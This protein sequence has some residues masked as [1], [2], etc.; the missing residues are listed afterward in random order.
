MTEQPAIILL[1]KSALKIAERLQQALPHAELHGHARRLAKDDVAVLFDDLEPHLQAL[2]RANRPILA[3]TSAAIPIRLLAPILA[4][5]T[6]EPPVLAIA[7]DGSAVVPLLGGHRGAND[8]SRQ[9][10][11][12]LG[13]KPAITTAGDLRLGLALDQPPPGWTIVTP[14]AIKP[15]TAAL[16]A[17]D[18]VSLVG[19]IS[20]IGSADWLNQSEVVFTEG[21]TSRIV[22]TDQTATTQ[23]NKLVYHPTTLALGVGCERGM[24]PTE[25]IDLVEMTLVKHGLAKTSIAAVVSIEL[26]AAEPAI[27]ALANHLGVPARFFSAETLNT[28]KERLANPSEIVFKETG[29]HGVAEGAALKSAGAGGALVV[30]KTKS[31]RATCAIARAVDVVDPMT[32]GRPQG[33]L[34]IIGI[35]PGMASWRTP[36]ADHLLQ[37]ADDW[38]GYHGYLDILD[39]QGLA[40]AAKARHGFALGEEETRARIAL[41][42]A[43]NG[44]RVALISSGDAGIYA[45]ASLAFELM[46]R[47][48]NPAWQRI[49]VIVSPGISALQAAASRAGAPLGH[50]FCAISLSDLLTPWHVIEQRL[51]AAADGDFIVALYNPASGRRR[52]GLARALAILGKARP[53]TTPVIIG[54]NLGREGENMLV[55]TLQDVDQ[56]SIDMLSLIIIGSSQTKAADRLH[57]RPFVYTPRGYLDDDKALS[58]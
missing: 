31:A 15:V 34:A 9:V 44:R 17:G 11:K 49:E 5:K 21:G 42:L 18:P 55:T 45:M 40:K 30:E 32:L 12:A 25:L 23:P 41:D 38:V 54:K 57:G 3:L 22:V 2:Y 6:S 48:Q 27:H 16:L 7:E 26:K 52:Q 24:E 51:N 56:D 53:A 39:E 20:S 4:D 28:Q 1:G 50:D 47:E 46:D 29:C 13:I 8:F 58:A 14:E 37:T 10:A 43:A 36:E 33:Q 19:N 35:G